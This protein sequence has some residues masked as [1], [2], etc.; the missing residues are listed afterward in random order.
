MEH[1]SLLTRLA[2]KC[3]VSLDTSSGLSE[4]LSSILRP[5]LAMSAFLCL[6]QIPLLFRAHRIETTTLATATKSPNSF[7]RYVSTPANVMLPHL[8]PSTLSRRPK[9]TST[10]NPR[11]CTPTTQAGRCRS[12]PRSL[13]LPARSSAPHSYPTDPP[14][15][16]SAAWN[17]P[18]PPSKASSAARRHRTNTSPSRP[19]HSSPA[20]PPA[21]RRLA[22][23]RLRPMVAA[24]GAQAVST[25]GP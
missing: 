13:N 17:K 7:V 20:A 16:R 9:G 25:A 6:R 11:P 1:C 2:G 4:A 21:P 23:A 22:H 24:K 10:P 12:P 8:L 19:H 15:P 5:D 14:P 3:L 18:S